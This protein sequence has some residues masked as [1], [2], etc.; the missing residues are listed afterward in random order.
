[1]DYLS[2]SSLRALVEDISRIGDMWKVFL[3]FCV[4]MGVLGTHIGCTHV[5]DQEVNEIFY[6]T[7]MGLVKIFLNDR[8][9]LDQ[10]LCR[11]KLVGLRWASVN[12][13]N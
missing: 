12:P 13:S 10:S 8:Y 11:T 9:S 1:M 3:H 4:S 6:L 5:Y 2:V 7:Q